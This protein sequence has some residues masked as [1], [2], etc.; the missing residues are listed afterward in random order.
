M[1]NNGGYIVSSRFRIALFYAYLIAILVLAF[2]LARVVLNNAKIAHE[3]H[4]ALCTLKVERQHRFD[5]SRDILTHPNKPENAQLIAKFGRPII[6][7]SFA[8][9]KADLDALK[10]VSC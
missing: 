5:Q 4:R 10:D 7:R 6:I 1:P 2:F 8:T 3:S 9:A